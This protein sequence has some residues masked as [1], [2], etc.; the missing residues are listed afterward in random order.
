MEP[1]QT[2]VRG[3]EAEA[4]AEVFAAISRQAR[5]VGDRMNPDA[6]RTLEHLAR[7]L[8]ALTGGDA[9]ASDA[10]SA[11]GLLMTGPGAPR[12]GGHKVGVALELE[13]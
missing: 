3:A 9:A 13:Q 7:V 6:A 8:A 11:G 5:S 12:S 10:D 4:R 1:V 2:E